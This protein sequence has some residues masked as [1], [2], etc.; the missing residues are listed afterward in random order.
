MLVVSGWDGLTTNQGVCRRIFQL[1]PEKISIL[2][3]IISV[4]LDRWLP[5]HY[6]NGGTEVLGVIHWH[7][8]IS[9]LTHTLI[10]HRKDG[11]QGYH[12]QSHNSTA[13]SERKV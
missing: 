6:G 7:E 1:R 4:D 10:R 8:P 12:F 9:A 2:L 5:L 3:R 13:T 11:S